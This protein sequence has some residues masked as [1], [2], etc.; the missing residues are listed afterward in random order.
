MKEGIRDLSTAI[1]LLLVSILVFSIAYPLLV[2]IGGLLWEGPSGGS[3][4]RFR[5]EIV[6]SK[7][8]GQDFDDNRFFHGRPSSIDYDAMRSG[9]R[10]LGPNNPELEDRVEENLL[11]ISNF[12]ENENLR[13]PSDLVTES[14]SALDPHISYRSAIF[15]VPRVSEYTDIPENELEEMVRSCAEDKLLGLFGTKRVN[16]LELNIEVSKQPEVD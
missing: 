2:G 3:P 6:G 7:L 9:S 8:I 16:V 10:N 14:G 1:R 11:R 12:Y 15:Q 5:G 4:V 13:V